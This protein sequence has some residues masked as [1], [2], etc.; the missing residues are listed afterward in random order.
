MNSLWSPSLPLAHFLIRGVVVYIAILLLMRLGGKRQ[1][2]QM[3]TGE[4]VTVLLISNAV[5][6]SMNGGDNSITGG[7]LL[8]AILVILSGIVSYLTFKSRR[9]E[10][11]LQGRPRLLIHGGKLI[12]KNLDKEFISLT[13]FKTILRKQGLHDLNEISEAVLESD[14]SVSVI[15][16]V[17]VKNTS[18]QADLS[19]T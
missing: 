11:F 6:N 4:F 1:V 17:D 2:G 3:G 15:R 16:K 8:A 14:G 10:N 12:E 5:Q 19:A 13:D 9:M 18:S 7:I